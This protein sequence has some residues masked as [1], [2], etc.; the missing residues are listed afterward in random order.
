MTRRRG[1]TQFVAPALLLIAVGIVGGL[2]SA[3][4]QEDITSVLISATMVIALYVFIGNSGVISFGQISFVALGAFAAGLMTIPSAVKPTVL[5]NLFPFLADH[6][7]G[8]FESLFLAAGLGALFAFLAGVPLMR[9]SGLAAGIATFAVLEITHNVL[10]F[11]DK[12]GPG[13]QTLAL[14]PEDVGPYEAML[15]ALFAATVA[16]LYQRSRSGRLLRAAREDP[17]AAQAVGVNIHRHRLVAFTISGALAGLAGG[18]LVHQIGSITT[19]QVYLELTFLTLAMLVV[20]GM[21]SLWGAVVGAVLVSFLDIFL[22]D[23]EG[24]VGVGPLDVDLPSGASLVILGA[25]MASMLIFRPAGITGGRELTLRLPRLGGR[26]PGE[27]PDEREAAAD[28]PQ[29]E[30]ALAPGTRSETPRSET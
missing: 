17:A 2:T 5:P 16:F 1:L 3:G 20:G 28:Q 11:W 23:A 4:T 9:L 21:G 12:I 19:E 15:G 25:L 10:R 27:Q 8:S 30:Q 26:G 22:V 14:V 13:A 29:P 18:L 6:S 24:G 7:V